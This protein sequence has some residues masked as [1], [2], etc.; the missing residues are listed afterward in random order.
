MDSLL[1]HL[2]TLTDRPIGTVV[3]IGAGDGRVLEHYAKLSPARVV[4]VEGD[5]DVGAELQRRAKA[6]A[7]AEVHVQPVAAL[8]GTLPWQ[9][10]NLKSLNGPLDAASLRTYYPRLRQVETLAIEALALPDLLT[11]L[12][13][14]VQ[15][16]HVRVLVLDVPGQEDALLAALSQDQLLVFDAVLLRGCQE[17]LQAGSATAEQALAQL[18]R[19]CYQPTPNG[20]ESEPLWPVNLLRLD[21]VRYQAEQYQ[22]Q[23]SAL[24]QTQQQSEQTI[25][26]LQAEQAHYA[27]SAEAQQVLADELRQQIDALTTDRDRQ[28]QVAEKRQTAL[29]VMTQ[30]CSALEQAVSEHQAQIDTLRQAQAAADQITSDQQLTIK[31]M[32]KARNRQT[33]LATERQAQMRTLKLAQATLEDTAQQQLAQIEALSQTADATADATAKSAAAQA[34]QI[35]ALTETLDSQTALAKACQA[36]LQT[37]RVALAAV[38]QAAQSEPQA[39]VRD[40]RSV[41]L[42]HQKMAD[43]TAQLRIR[44]LESQLAEAAIRQQLLQD[45]LL[46]AEGQI[47]LIK[48]LLLREPSL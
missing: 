30:R 45:E 34:A 27:A 7:W 3:H 8:A 43:D 18:T 21:P 12:A 35:E 41:T 23:M 10:Y 5:P 37:L 39:P 47:E 2:V 13:I 24:D 6:S 11:R 28:A 17:L 15:D 33:R 29:L 4:L 40:T 46:K 25:Q 20:R 42:A 16:T 19:R 44:Q 26:H 48:D 1:D 22:M 9:R 14:S 32:T 38:E 31:A 36:E